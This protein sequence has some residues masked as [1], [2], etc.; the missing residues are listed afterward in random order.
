MAYATQ[1]RCIKVV[2]DVYL[3]RFLIAWRQHLLRRA[4]LESISRETAARRR[5]RRL[6]GMLLHLQLVLPWIRRCD[7]LLLTVVWGFG[8][9]V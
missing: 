9:V 7:R 5:R 6:R 8:F 4:H 2:L 3:R 1:L